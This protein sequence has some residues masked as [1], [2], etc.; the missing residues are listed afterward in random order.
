MA[1]QFW[2]FWN[3]W[4]IRIAV[5]S[6][7][8]AHALLI[9]LAG[10]R[11][12]N[13][14]RVGMLLLWLAY[15]I[16]DIAGGYAL[17]NLTLSSATPSRERKQQLV[18]FWAPLLLLH[19]G[20]PDNIS[21]YA[22]EDNKLSLRQAAPVTAKVAGAAFVVCKY[23]YLSDSGALRPAAFVMLAAGVA[24]Y[25]EKACALLRADLSNIRDW[26]K[27]KKQRPGLGESRSFKRESCR[28][29][30]GEQA[31]LYAHH[32]FHICLRAM[33]DSSVDPASPDYRAGMKIFFMGWRSM[34]K[35]VEMELSLMY[36]VLYTKATVVY[37]W[38]GYLI[39]F[40]SPVA[41]AVAASLFQ[42][43]PKHDQRAADVKIT[44]ALLSAVFL[45]DVTWLLRALAS[46]WTY[47]FLMESR[48]RKWDWFRHSV[49]CKRRGRWHQL[50]RMVVSLDPGRLLG[51]KDPTA[52]RFWSG[53]I[54]LIKEKLRLTNDSNPGDDA[55][56]MKDITTSWGQKAYDRRPDILWDLELEFGHE[57]QEDILVWHIGTCIFFWR[58]R[59]H[60]CIKDESVKVIEALSEYLMFL[61]AVR[62]HMLPGLVLRSL[63]EETLK[64]LA[65]VWEDDK[66]S[67]NSTSVGSRK[68]R[69]AMILH[70]KNNQN[71]DLGIDERKSRLV[72]DGAELARALLIAS[73]RHM[74]QVLELIL[75]VWVDKLLYAGTQCSRE[76]HAKQL[77]R[78]GELTTI[79]WIMA[80]HASPFRI[81]ERAVKGTKIPIRE[82]EEEEKKTKLRL[83]KDDDA[84]KEHPM[85]DGTPPSPPAPPPPSLPM[86]WLPPS[87]PNKPPMPPPRP[88]K[89]PSPPPSRPRPSRPPPPPTATPPPPVSTVKPKEDKE[90]ED[91]EESEEDERPIS[92]VTLYPSNSSY[93]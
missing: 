40:V 89:P 79:V 1:A 43:Y 84:S 85:W 19:L 48:L 80:E 50:R 24:K 64:A 60:A 93:R 25:V 45:L 39:R 4:L 65:E 8:G 15:Q 92:Y 22:Q 61:V 82:K 62:K 78:G 18:A 7:F 41:T 27:D 20:G 37:T 13:T 17:A 66:H 67:R 14:S 9:L 75:D 6:S 73:R 70:G 51:N 87:A 83:S 10:T 57:F 42:A 44:Y 81:G 36:D 21:A 26:S 72:S 5:L 49:L 32:L 47:G 29:L 91:L 30:G 35:V 11:R 52:Y 34:C 76:S 2:S 23:I 56:T 54:G 38:G 16:A 77:S 59:K 12:R 69:L 74:K 63:F 3:E 71:Q 33:V 53:K 55:Y 88:P 58:R 68:E 28:K 31:L 90:L 46:T 86:P